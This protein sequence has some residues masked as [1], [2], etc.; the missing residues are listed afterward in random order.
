MKETMYL[1]DGVFPEASPEE[2]GVSSRDIA[3]D[4]L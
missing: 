2:E 1:I 3:G 4:G